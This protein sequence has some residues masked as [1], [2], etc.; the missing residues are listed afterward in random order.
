MDRFIAKLQAYAVEREQ[1]LA[2]LEEKTWENSNLKRESMMD[3]LVAKEVDLVRLQDAHTKLCTRFES[4]GQDMLKDTLQ[5]LSH[6]VWDKDIE[7]DALGV[8]A[9]A[10][11]LMNQTRNHEVTGSI[12]GLTQWVKDLVLPWAV[13]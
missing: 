7:I 6:T 1:I 8:P 5:N 11:W 4:S 12:P 3:I 2:V 9:V 10:Q 13:V